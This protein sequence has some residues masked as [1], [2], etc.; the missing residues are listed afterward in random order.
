MWANRGDT[1]IW[2]R[3]MR[4]SMQSSPMNYPIYVYN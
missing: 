4:C 2:R 1:R 3:R